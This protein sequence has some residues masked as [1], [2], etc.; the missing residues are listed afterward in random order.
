[1]STNPAP[2]TEVDVTIAAQ[3]LITLH[4]DTNLT[5]H[6][7]GALGVFAMMLSMSDAD[8]LAYAQQIA[9]D[10]ARVVAHIPPL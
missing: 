1:M 4:A 3:W 10:R 9:A 5:G 2:P 8:A 6:Y 7:R